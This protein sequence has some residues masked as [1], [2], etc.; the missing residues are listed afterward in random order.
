MSPLKGSSYEVFCRLLRDGLIRPVTKYDIIPEGDIRQ[1]AERIVDV[2]GLPERV[3]SAKQGAAL[4]ELEIDKILRHW[5]DQADTLVTASQGAS[6]KRARSHEPEPVNSRKK[7]KLLAKPSNGVSEGTVY[8]DDD[9]PLLNS[10]AT[11]KVDTYEASSSILRSNIAIRENYEKYKVIMRNRRLYRLAFKNLGKEAAYIY[12]I[13][14][15]LVEPQTRRCYDPLE[16]NSNNEE[17]DKLTMQESPAVTLQHI[18]N[19]LECRPRPEF[20][21]V[22]S[23]K[24]NGDVPQPTNGVNGHLTGHGISSDSEEDGPV[25]EHHRLSKEGVRRWSDNLSSRLKKIESYL[26]ILCASPERF[27]RRRGAGYVVPYGRLT[28]LLME[29]TLYDHIAAKPSLGTRCARVVRILAW[30]GNCDEKMVSDRAMIPLLEAR[31]MLTRL[32]NS[33]LIDVYPVARDNQRTASR[34]MYIYRFDFAAVRVKI[35][36]DCYK[37]MFNLLRTLKEAKRRA[38]FVLEKAERS[39]VKGNEDKYLTAGEQEA[40]KQVRK[41]EDR[42]LMH[43]DALDD[44]V[45]ALRDWWPMDRHVPTLRDEFGLK[46]SGVN[47]PVMRRGTGNNDDDEDDDEEILQGRASEPPGPTSETEQE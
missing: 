24:P 32:W 4:R 46:K 11:L 18:R 27:L 23:L 41:K 35:I 22:L 1:E 20:D 36:G 33:G 40:L 42:V 43:V 12:E 25:Q 44:L 2:N 37:S 16:V 15:Q 39:D 9:M 8:N 19:E 29:E 38:H 28:P 5:R 7:R 13:V 30:V 6:K 31:Q 26:E 10:S 47:N 21:H 3:A 45:G 34:S 14:L 17:L